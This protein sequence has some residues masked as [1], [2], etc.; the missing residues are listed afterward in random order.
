M[1]GEIFIRT[2]L[3]Y[4]AYGGMGRRKFRGVTSLYDP[5]RW[6]PGDGAGIYVQ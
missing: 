5:E 4:G 3:Y 1:G 2:V 6:L